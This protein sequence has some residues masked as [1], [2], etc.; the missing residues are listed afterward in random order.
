[1]QAVR[2]D[3]WKHLGLRPDLRLLHRLPGEDTMTPHS[4]IW[5]ESQVCNRVCAITAFSRR[6]VC[7]S[8]KDVEGCRVPRCAQTCRLTISHSHCT[9]HLTP[10]RA[11]LASP[12]PVSKSEYPRLYS[13]NAWKRVSA[14]AIPIVL[15]SIY[16]CT[17]RRVLLRVLPITS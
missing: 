12:W 7:L 8:R 14:S 2:G 9:T 5:C 16:Y 10:E 3:E 17:S 11:F 1:M 13:R 6:P 4:R 15:L